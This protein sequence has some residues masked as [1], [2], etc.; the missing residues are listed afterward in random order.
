MGS[1]GPDGPHR[2][3]HKDLDKVGVQ[4]TFVSHVTSKQ[5]LKN[6]QFCTVTGLPER[7]IHVY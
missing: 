4:G 2:L 5:H 6:V 1:N 3:S 7:E